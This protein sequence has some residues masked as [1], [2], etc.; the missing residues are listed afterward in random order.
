MRMSETGFPYMHNTLH[1]DGV[2]G[3]AS[4][5]YSSGGD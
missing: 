5:R 1:S 2:P 4:E 3:I